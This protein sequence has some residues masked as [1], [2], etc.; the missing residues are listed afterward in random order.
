MRKGEGEEGDEEE[1]GKKFYLRDRV[2]LRGV[3][4]EEK[5]RTSIRDSLTY[6]LT[7]CITTCI[8]HYAENRRTLTVRKYR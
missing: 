7:Q 1:E 6:K 5:R 4:K 3:I 2:K 8:K